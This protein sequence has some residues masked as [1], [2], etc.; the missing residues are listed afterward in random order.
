MVSLQESTAYYAA[1]PKRDDSTI[2][3]R[4]IQLAQEK[5]RYGRP[6]I[7]WLLRKEGFLDNH[8]RIARIYCEERLQMHRRKGKKKR[9][10]LRLV[11]PIP[12]KPNQRWS[13]DFVSDS[14]SDGRRF[15][16]LTI[17]DDCTRECLA[18]EVDIGISGQRVSEV[19]DRIAKARGFPKAIV[20]DNGP[21]FISKA[22]SQWAYERKVDLK[23]IQPGKPVQNAFIESFNGKFRM[24]CLDLHWFQNL[25]HAKE[26]IEKWRK[27]YNQERPHSSLK[28]QTPEQFAEKFKTV[29]CG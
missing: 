12:E 20:S 29:L 5:P 26:I 2:K 7:T 11:M 3:E 14:F 17:V 22:M 21:E 1:Q 15:R 19:L 25:S 4:M 16:T 9:T 24:E 13:M 27:E 10:G 8:K 23:F 6:R 28:K 18:L